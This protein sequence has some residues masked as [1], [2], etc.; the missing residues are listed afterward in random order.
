M[1]V[2]ALFLDRDGTLVEPRHY[3]SRPDQL[4]L[5]PG[6]GPHLAR[7]RAHGFRLV[8]ITNQAGLAHGYFTVAD[9]ERMH[10]HLA[11]K[12]AGLGVRLDAVYHCPH[13]PDGAIPAL[14]RRCDCRKPA[15]GMLLRAAADLDLDLARSW[16]LGDIL[17]D[18]EAGNRA[19]C[20]TVLVDLGTEAPPTH[21]LRRPHFVA[22]DT[23]HALAIA[24]ALTCGD[25]TADL[26]Y[27]P[28]T[29]RP[30]AAPATPPS[31]VA[32]V[33]PAPAPLSGAPRAAATPAGG[34]HA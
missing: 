24:R 2:P 5:Y 10:A 27:Q 18:V 4:Q 8:V 26:T 21:P 6:L 19:G 28:P 12:L 13:H 15:P 33:S 34:R 16:F 30:V 22:R 29:W 32:A 7:L 11:A 25:I 3:P 23:R 31:P 9:L 14:A 1:S 20:R 17:D